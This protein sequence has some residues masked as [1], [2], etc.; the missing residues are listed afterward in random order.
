MSYEFKKL[1]DVDVVAEPTESANV[2]IEENGVIKKAPKT[3]VGGGEI[4]SVL[5]YCVPDGETY[6]CTSNVSYAEFESLVNGNQ[7]FDIEVNVKKFN[8][9]GS[10]NSLVKYRINTITYNASYQYYN[11]ACDRQSAM[12]GFFEDRIMFTLPS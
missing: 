9:D 4:T 6:T 1:S 11:L 8:D 2:L 7:S 5:I 12:V 3:A 10:F